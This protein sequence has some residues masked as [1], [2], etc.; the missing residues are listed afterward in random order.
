MLQVGKI[1][2]FNKSDWREGKEVYAE[3]RTFLQYEHFLVLSSIYDSFIKRD[4]YEILTK[5]GIEHLFCT[6]DPE[7]KGYISEC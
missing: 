4:N 2:K 1:Y 7:T 5:E 3:G 6:K